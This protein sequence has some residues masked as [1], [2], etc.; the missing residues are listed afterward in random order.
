MCGIIGYTGN[1]EA[2]PILLDGLRQ[3]EYRG[4]DSAGIAVMDANNSITIK[5]AAGKLNSLILSLNGNHPVGT[6][7]IGHT[8]WATHGIANEANSHPHQDCHGNVVVVHNGIVENYLELK[9]EL[10]NHGHTFSSMTDSEVIPH[11]IESLMTDG[12]SAEE[13][14]RQTALRLVGAHAVVVIFNNDP[15][16]LLAFRNGNAGGIVVG[17][18]DGEMLLGSD[19]PA[20]ISITKR[21]AFLSANEMVSLTHNTASYSS[22]QGT[23]IEKKPHVAPYDMVSVAKG[24]YKHFM[25][26][27]I[28]E[29]PEAI[30]STIRDRIS[31]DTWDISLEDVKFTDS[32]I[33]SINRVIFTAMGTSLNA[34]RVARHMMEQLSGVP[35]EAENASEFRYRD[36]IIDSHT[37]VVSVSQSGETVDTLSAM[38]E[39]AQKDARLIA[40]C[41][42]E[43][44]QAVRLA[45]GHIYLKA[46]PEIGVASTKTFVCSLEA[47]YM[48]SA[49][50]GL[51]RGFLSRSDLRE[52]IKELARMPD[53]LGRIIANH[54]PYLHLAELYHE[55]SNFL[56]I[57]RGVNY[58]VALEG[59]L[60]LKEISYIHAEGTPAG[61]MKHGPIALIDGNMPVVAIVPMDEL[62]DKMLNNISEVKTRG[63][64][65]IALATEGD[66]EIANLVDHVLYIPQTSRL[67][68]PI[69]AS[70]P[71][72]LLAYYIAVR[73]GCDVDQP[74]NL[75]KTVTV[76]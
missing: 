73:R 4:Y 26:K 9:Q 20:I 7:G 72:Q 53:L 19:L 27:E 33:R 14:T 74:R 59:A 66:K 44:S 28:S 43:E 40:I 38:E 22:L 49:Y 56:Y 32:E 57:G 71:M 36:P 31:F 17:Y 6:I 15:E 41:N 46:G 48:L 5:K 23:T 42:V 18:G 12:M 21:I 25:L 39:A 3:L 55:K 60:K 63:G 69:L 16:K 75:A 54:E 64:T 29:Q 76:E 35:S 61:E 67:L 45:E 51:H 24:G 2:T 70:V 1:R 47:L 62:R 52:A 30:I 68:T 37:L 11:L 65:I 58:P 8:R 13:A 50:I 10:L 34:A